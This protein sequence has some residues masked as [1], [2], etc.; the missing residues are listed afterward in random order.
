GGVI[1][2]AALIMIV[3]FGSFAAGDVLEIQTLGVGMAVAVAADATL[4]RGIIVPALMRLLG[5]ANWWAPPTLQ[6][7]IA[8]LG[9]YE[10][11]PKLE[12]EPA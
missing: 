8:R 4:V 12:L 5:G 7:W 11:D 9:L 10:P 3:V 6:V 2:S 1:T